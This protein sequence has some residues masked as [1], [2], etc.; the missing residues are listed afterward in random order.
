MEEVEVEIVEGIEIPELVEVRSMEVPVQQIIVNN[1]AQEV[2][3]ECLVLCCP[4]CGAVLQ[5]FPVGVSA[6]EV[7]LNL[8]SDDEKLLKTIVHCRNCGQALKIFRPMPV[9]AEFS[10]TTVEE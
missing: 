6:A 1:E 5:Q 7:A 3:G 8:C 4:K 10:V 9:D 2:K